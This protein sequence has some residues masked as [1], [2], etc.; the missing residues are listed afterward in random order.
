MSSLLIRMS[1]PRER[2]NEPT[3][4][5]ILKELLL[6][7]ASEIHID[8]GNRFMKRIAVSGSIA[9]VNINARNKVVNSHAYT[10]KRTLITR[11]IMDTYST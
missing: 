6:S 8:F 9:N 2:M 10:S 3:I 4:P 11:D 7:S 5:I 1:T